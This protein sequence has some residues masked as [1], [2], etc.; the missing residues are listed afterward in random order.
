MTDLEKF[1][2]VMFDVFRLNSEDI[3]EEYGPDEIEN[4]DS[5]GH[6]DLIAALEEK[7]DI[8]LP[9]DDVSRMYTIRDIKSVLKK[10]GVEV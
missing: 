7:F 1:N 6:F 2:K 9:I 10:Y 5:L 4:W 3:K 8:S